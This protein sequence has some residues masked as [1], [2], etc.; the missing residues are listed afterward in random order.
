[1]RFRQ[2]RGAIRDLDEALVHYAR[3]HAT[4]VRSLADEVGVARQRIG[5]QPDAWHPLGAGLRRYVLRRFPY[6]IIYRADPEEIVIVAYAHQ[7]RRPG[8][9]R[10]RLRTDE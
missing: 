4:L 10:N 6:T 1:M 5:E 8:F 3:I 9:W 2:L 7:R